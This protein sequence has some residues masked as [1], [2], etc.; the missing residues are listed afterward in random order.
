LI[1]K[2]AGITGRISEYLRANRDKRGLKEAL[3]FMRSADRAA[4]T[5]YDTTL[6]PIGKFLNSAVVKPGIATGKYT[7][8]A[9]LA[10][11]KFLGRTGWAT[12]KAGWRLAK[13]YPRTAVATGA[14][15]VL[16]TLR[17][18]N[19]FNKNVLHTDPNTDVTRMGIGGLRY[20]NPQHSQYY[21]DIN[22]VY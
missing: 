4:E 6:K 12:G 15:G 21:D 17:A 14:L 9:G 7:G 8:K 5:A 10:T 22:L 2:H 3:N 16:G 20:R 11:G 1:T 13:K 19:N 18:R